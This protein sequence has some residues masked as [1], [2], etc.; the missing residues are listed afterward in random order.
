[1]RVSLSSSPSPSPAKM[2][3]SRVRRKSTILK[4]AR[5]KKLRMVVKRVANAL[6]VEADSC[7]SRKIKLSG[8]MD[9]SNSAK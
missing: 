1:M 4:K 9:S 5:T 2:S 3:R 6:G 7:V 8:T